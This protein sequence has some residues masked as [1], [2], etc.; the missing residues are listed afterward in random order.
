MYLHSLVP[1]GLQ[2]DTFDITKL[3]LL[4]NLSQFD[5][6]ADSL[7]T[8]I[9]VI[10][11]KVIKKSREVETFKQTAT[12]KKE[13]VHSYEEGICE[14]EADDES[15]ESITQ[16]FQLPIVSIL[17]ILRVV[18]PFCAVTST[19]FLFSSPSMLLLN[20]LHSRYIYIYR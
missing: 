7:N 3:P 11:Q 13:P 18:R 10:Q 8:E 1:F 19:P 5:D 9:R 17:D 14:L 12:V 6:D 15:D 4:P 20:S 2:C 16:P